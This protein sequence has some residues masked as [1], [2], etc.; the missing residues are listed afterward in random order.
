MPAVGEITDGLFFHVRAIRQRTIFEQDRA[1]RSI[2]DHTEIVNAL[3][4][5]DADLAERLVREH[6]LRLREHV[7]R[8]VSLD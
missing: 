3:E 8:Y 4:A 5:R 6:T 1:K 2:V 7:E